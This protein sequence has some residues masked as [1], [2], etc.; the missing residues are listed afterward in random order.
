MDQLQ[1][2]PSTEQPPETPMADRHDF[3]DQEREQRHAERSSG[4]PQWIFGVVIVLLGVIFL[5][6]NMGLLEWG[7][8]WALL[9]LVPAA[10]SFITAWNGYRRSGGHFPPETRGAL[11]GG[12]ALTT[13]AVLFLFHLDWAVHWP[14]FVIL[15]GVAVLLAAVLPE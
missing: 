3:Q 11:I 10:G 2:D 15:G 6:R 5:L 8:W 4:R 13:V 12:L 1:P 9:L 14:L 7:N